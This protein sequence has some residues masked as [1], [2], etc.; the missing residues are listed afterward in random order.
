MKHHNER[1]CL[2]GGGAQQ[3]W[4]KVQWRGLSCLWGAGMEVELGGVLGDGFGG[5]GGGF[6]AGL[7]CLGVEF[8]LAALG[9]ALSD[10][11]LVACDG[12][13]LLGFEL[14]FGG[15]G[16]DFCLGLEE[17]LGD[18][19]VLGIY[20]VAE[21][22]G[23]G[24]LGDSGGDICWGLV[25]DFGHAVLE[26]LGDFVLLTLEALQGGKE[27]VGPAEGV[28]GLVEALGDALE[29][30]KA[31]VLE[32]V[33]GSLDGGAEGGGFAAEGNQLSVPHELAFVDD[34]CLV[35]HIVQ[36]VV[37]GENAVHFGPEGSGLPEPVDEVIH[38]VELVDPPGGLLDPFHN[39]LYVLAQVIDHGLCAG[40]V[41]GDDDGVADAEE[42]VGFLGGGAE[43]EE[44]G[45]EEGSGGGFHGLWALR[46]FLREWV[47]PGRKPQTA[48]E[49]KRACAASREFWALMT[50]RESLASLA[51]RRWR[52]IWGLWEPSGY[53]AARRAAQSREFR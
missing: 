9:D 18:G 5:A 33:E 38:L 40:G 10:E 4:D 53:L 37:D 31:A 17:P 30:L 14:V 41:E 24:V 48:R 32:S 45:G 49:E 19:S 46:A 22:D 43:A 39:L 47:E 3:F 27:A 26:G 42:C 34:A 44:G 12:L 25:G 29:A 28:V 6:K 16:V 13:F 51:Q 36:A 15:H 2:E 11:S 20:L 21:H 1:R 23:G 7:L 50:R 35:T 8:Y 52:S